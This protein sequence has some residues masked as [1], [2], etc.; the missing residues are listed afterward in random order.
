MIGASQ[1]GPR[2]ERAEARQQRDDPV[3]VAPKPSVNVSDITDYKAFVA[4]LHNVG[5]S[6]AF[7]RR[8]TNRDA[9]KSAAEP[10]AD[11]QQVANAIKSQL[12]ALCETLKGPDHETKK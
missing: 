4:F 1:A 8:V 7:A 3:A 5:F 9:F 12:A 6:R 10:S 2:V 11:N